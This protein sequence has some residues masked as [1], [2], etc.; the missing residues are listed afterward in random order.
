MCVLVDKNGRW[1]YHRCWATRAFDMETFYLHA[2][3]SCLSLGWHT[4]DYVTRL[5]MLTA[6]CKPWRVHI[7]SPGNWSMWSYLVREKDRERLEFLWKIT[8]FKRT[9]YRV[10]TR[11]FI[12]LCLVTFCDGFRK[13]RNANTIISS[14]EREYLKRHKSIQQRLFNKAFPF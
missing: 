2:A 8:W 10:I 6:G 3:R 7:R 14:E 4:R 5:W 13:D 1:K 9:D 11:F 12:S